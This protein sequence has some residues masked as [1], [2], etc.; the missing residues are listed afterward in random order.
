M[1]A[2]VRA[3]VC[4]C[5]CVCV[6]SHVC[7]RMSA[8]VCAHVCVCVCVCVLRFVS[9]FFSSS[10]FFFFFTSFSSASVFPGQADIVQRARVR[11]VKQGRVVAGQ[12][13]GT[14]QY[15]SL[16]SI[17]LSVREWGYEGSGQVISVRVIV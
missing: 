17:M 5:V 11:K 7:A 12:P 3:C 16:F 15:I 9:S 8:C 10:F 1:R 14:Q 6:N 2:C 13:T 4:V